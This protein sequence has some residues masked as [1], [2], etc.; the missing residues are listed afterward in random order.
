MDVARRPV[1]IPT[2]SQ[3]TAL[4]EELEVDFEWSPGFAVTQKQKSIRALHKAAGELGVSHVLEVSTKSL[5]SL[6]VTL[7]A[8]NLMVEVDDRP[9]SVEAAFQGSKVFDGGGPYTDLYE[10]EGSAIKRDDRLQSSGQLVAFDWNGE[11]WPLKP[12]TA[13]Y[14][15]LYINALDCMDAADELSHYE[16]FTDIEFN[17]AKSINCQARSCALYLSLRTRGVLQEVL[18]GTPDDFRR[19]LASGSADDA[20][21]RSLL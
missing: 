6:G 5:D 15:W 9:I 19:R 4:V 10:L 1:F 20:S 16:G 12:R 21:Q 13:F 14:D 3:S 2:D 17:P 8:F 18:A 11:R 7:S